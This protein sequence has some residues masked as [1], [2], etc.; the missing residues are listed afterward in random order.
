MTKQNAWIDN[1][2]TAL[3]ALDM[4]DIIQP[5]NEVQEGDNVVGEAD[6]DL[7]K[8]YGYAMMMKRTG[9]QIMVSIHFES[10]K[11]STGYQQSIERMLEYKGKHE[12]LM[13]I[14]WV[15][16]KDKYNLWSKDSVGVRKGWKVVWH[17]NDDDN[18]IR[19]FLG[20]IFGGQ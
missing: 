6:D 14:F 1:L 2:K 9:M 11:S 4:K 15:A 13:S 3:D 10:D 17:K 18:E 20:K 7:K 19:D 8:I 5:N 12:A 16:L